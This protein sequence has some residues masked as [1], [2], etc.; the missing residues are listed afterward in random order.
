MSPIDW[1]R[2]IRR[3]RW[4][5]SSADARTCSHCRTSLPGVAR[6]CYICGEAVTDSGEMQRS[7]PVSDAAVGALQ[8]RLAHVLDGRYLVGELL[9]SGGMGVVFLADDLALERRVAIKVLRPEIAEPDDVERFQREAKT[10]AKLDHPHI[11]PIHSVESGAGLH[12]FVMKY[13]PG[14]SL[15]S[16]LDEGSMLPIPL[17][18][19]VLREA[20]AALGHAH[21]HGV[22]HRDVK[23]A[24]IMLDADERVVLTD[25]GIS[26]RSA[27][28][29]ATTP[30]TR[31]G[32]VVGTPHYMAPEQ[33]LGQTVDGRADQYALAVVGFRMLTGVLPFDGDTSQAILHRHIT[34]APPHL[35]T[36]RAE[37]PAHL[38]AAIARALS[39]APSHRFGTMEGFAAALDGSPLPAAT[40][41]T[42]APATAASPVSSTDL[43]STLVLTAGRAADAPPTRR[44]RA[45]TWAALAVLLVSGVAGAAGWASSRATPPA[46][47]EGA[48][49]AAAAAPRAGAARP[50]V[51]KRDSA[52][53]RAVRPAASARPAAPASR[54]SSSTSRPPAAAP[55]QATKLTIASKPRATVIIDGVRV[56]ETP[57]AGYRVVVG[58]T[59]RIRLERKGYVGKRDSVV[60]TSTRPI[61]RSYV[62]KER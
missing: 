35:L 30:L 38:R 18:T 3:P 2:H 60:V 6:F 15:E 49:V 5:S 33:A 1:F 29:V 39:K 14:R 43:P 11:I 42:S 9:G 8:E 12:Y 27:E 52:A 32:T 62:L 17:V 13:V 22:V 59:Y 41:R 54:R 48:A 58:R 56:G 53:S 16:V 4:L 24:N 25:F 46:S 55:R 34:E 10:A 23:P 40:A 7:E 61:S 50:A 20:G 31:L 47:P 37:V 44:R 45:A 57:I 36:L 21:R 51:A 26:K 19:R 28:G